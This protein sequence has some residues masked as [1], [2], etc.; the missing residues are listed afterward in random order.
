SQAVP[1]YSLL[2]EAQAR[3]ET[4]SPAASAKKSRRW[5][6]P[7]AI[8][9]VAMLLVTSV[10]M[11][12]RKTAPSAPAQAPVSMPPPPP[13]PVIAT[14]KAQVIVGTAN[15]SAPVQPEVKNLAGRRGFFQEIR[16]PYLLRYDYDGLLQA[17]QTGKVK[18]DVANPLQFRKGIE[19]MAEM[20]AWVLERLSHCTPA[21]PLIVPRFAIKGEQ[22]Y[23]IYS[24]SPDK[25]VVISDGVPASSTLAEMKPAL[26][27]L[28]LLAAIKNDPGVPSD[29]IFGAVAFART[30]NLPEM[31][32]ELQPLGGGKRAAK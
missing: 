31:E 27:S 2:L 30:Y 25:I 23:K 12:T 13:V 26:L 9:V 29:V 1:V 19:H 22:D 18:P 15:V 4:P 21:Q 24:E 3:T 20:K 32:I 8:A 16:E 10:V 14:P 5:L 11:R 28:I 7:A 6:L 17:I